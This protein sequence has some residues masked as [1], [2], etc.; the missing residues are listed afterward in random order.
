M[1][2]TPSVN[3]I[4]IKHGTFDTLADALD[5]A[6]K[7]VTGFNFYNRRGKLVKSLSYALLRKEART[8]ARKILYAG[9]PRGSHMAI[10]ANTHPDFVRFFFACQY[11][12]IVP[13]PLPIVMHFSGAKGYVKQI[14]RLLKLSNAKLAVATEEYLGFLKEAAKGLELDLIGSPDEFDRLPESKAKLQPLDSTELAYLQFTSGSTRF[15]KGVMVKQSAVMN[16]IHIITHHGINCQK[17]DRAVSWLPFY[18]DMGLVGLVLASLGTQIS[19]DFFSTAD[20][21]MRPGL[22]IKLMSENKGTVSFSPP[23]GYELAAMR[24]RSNDIAQFDLSGWRVAGVGAEMIRPELLRKFAQRLKPC[25]FD[26]KAFMPCYGMAECSLA[27]SFSVVGQ[28]LKVD[29]V[30]HERLVENNEIVKVDPKS[31]NGS[32]IKEFVRCGRLL[33]GFEAEIRDENGV[34]LSEDEG[35]CGTLFLRGPSIMDGYF[36][37]PEATKEVLSPDGW[38]D[39]GDIAYISESEIVIT[40][41]SKD[42]I[43]INGR[44]IWPQDIEYLAETM[45]EVRIGDAC[46][47]SVTDSSGKERAVVVVQLRNNNGKDHSEFIDGLK[48][49]I[50]TELGI[51]CHVEIVPKNTLVRTTSGKPSRNG[52]KKYCL[53]HGL[54]HLN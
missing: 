11:A 51:D 35:R 15:P 53:K 22:W 54:I 27:V 7:G 38:L 5:Y 40:G 24:L 47:F 46:A 49:L 1:D 31:S 37:D 18:H 3:T 39:T 34:V 36:N 25:G 43:I 30:D 50:A 21:A 12:G 48:G 29:L 52:T 10:V 28:G 23:F 41:R 17:G 2:P 33:P 4:P 44:N 6:A 16:N 19:V 20:F 32:K 13:V 8:L 26:E 42:L 9:V 45:D 14:H